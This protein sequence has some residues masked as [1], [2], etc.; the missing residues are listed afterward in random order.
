MAQAYAKALCPAIEALPSGSR[1][2]RYGC[3]HPPDHRILPPAAG[4]IAAG[5]AAI[6]R[7]T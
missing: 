7:G 4:M 1:L 2:N 6:T 3:K 5:S